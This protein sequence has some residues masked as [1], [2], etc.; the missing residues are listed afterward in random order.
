MRRRVSSPAAGP[1][2]ALRPG[3]VAGSHPAG[4]PHRPK[5]PLRMLRD[6]L[7][8]LNAVLKLGDFPRNDIYRD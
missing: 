1:G 4:A 3:P 2:P 5:P 7:A 6:V 8:G